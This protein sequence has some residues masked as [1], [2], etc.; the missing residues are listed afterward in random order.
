MNPMAWK[1]SCAH[2]TGENEKKEDNDK[3]KKKRRSKRRAPV[4]PRG[5]A[6]WPKRRSRRGEECG[7][8]V[9]SRWGGGVQ[10]ASPGNFL[11]KKNGAIWCILRSFGCFFKCFKTSC[12]WGLLI[13][14]FHSPTP[15]IRP[16]LEAFLFFKTSS[17][18]GGEIMSPPPLQKK[19]KK[20]KKR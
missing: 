4:L 11:K 16:L 7:R 13:I 2:R 15:I 19:K 12:L 6:A 17:L 14:I 3:I 9:P 20:K 1:A 10:W 5:R 8:G 18:W